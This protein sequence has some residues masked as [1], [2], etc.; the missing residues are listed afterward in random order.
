MTLQALNAWKH[1]RYLPVVAGEI[2]LPPIKLRW[3]DTT[4]QQWQI[5]EL[6]GSKYTVAASRTAGA[7]S[8]LKGSR[9]TFTWSTVLLLTGSL[10]L[11]VLMFIFR[12]TLL[13]SARVIY[14]T[15]GADSGSR[16]RYRDK[17][18]I[19]GTHNEAYV[20]YTGFMRP[21][22]HRRG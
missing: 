13:R 18:Q 22:Q 17:P 6:P 3:W 16:F 19:T 4:H 12:R 5:A 21:L 10:A 20:N 15:A 14:L 7:E 11:L 8:V 9:D 2:T 1:S